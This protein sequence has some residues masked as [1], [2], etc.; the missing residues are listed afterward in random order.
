MDDDELERRF[1]ALMGRVNDNHEAVLI[2]LRNL[3]TTVDTT[4]GVRYPVAVAD[5]AGITSPVA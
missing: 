1:D 5:C 4:S 2:Y 3:R